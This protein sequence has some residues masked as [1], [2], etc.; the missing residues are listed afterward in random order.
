[1]TN[2]II[3]LEID[4]TLETVAKLFLTRVLTYILLYS[5]LNSADLFPKKINKKKL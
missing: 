2:A 3:P 5:C 4:E 1:M